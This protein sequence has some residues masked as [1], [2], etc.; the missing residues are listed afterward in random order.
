MEDAGNRVCQAISQIVA[1][2]GA[3]N[4]IPAWCATSWSPGQEKY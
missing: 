1:A 2:V 4:A 3:D